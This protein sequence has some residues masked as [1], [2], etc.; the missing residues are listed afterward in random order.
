SPGRAQVLDRVGKRGRGRVVIGQLDRDSSSGDDLGRGLGKTTRAKTRVVP[1]D[2]AVS[3]LFVLQNVGGNGP[4]HAP[5][6]FKGVIVGNH[7]APAV[8]AKLYLSS[9]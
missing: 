3:G 9:H 5:D 4:S 6:I 1:D 7:A 2:H 8:G